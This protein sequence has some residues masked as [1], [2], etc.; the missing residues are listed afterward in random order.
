MIMAQIPHNETERLADLYALEIL[1][2]ASE[3]RFDRITR[4]ATRLFDV[5][6][7]YVAMID[8]NRQW[9]K[10]KQGLCHESTARDISFCAHTI[11]RDEP[12]VIHDAREDDRFF[13]NPMVTGE[14]H[15]VFYAGHPLRGPGGTNVATLCVV[16]QK[17][18]SWSERDAQAFADLAAMVERELNM[19][20]LIEAQK[21]LLSLKNEIV[22]SRQALTEELN[23]AA[24]YVR[25]LLP[26]PM[27]T[28]L[29]LDWRYHA[30]SKLGGDAFG[31]HWL[32]DEHLAIYLLDVT[33]HGISSALLSI[34]IMNMI[35]SASLPQPADPHHVLTTLNRS[36]PMDDHDNKFFTMWYG[37]LHVPT[38]QLRYAGGGHPPALLISRGEN[39]HSNLHQLHSQG[40]VVGV[41]PEADY[42][43]TE[44]MLNC[45]D[46]LYLYSDGVFELFDEDRNLLTLSG[47]TELLHR[48][49]HAD[50]STPFLDRLLL[51]LREY[52]GGADD[53]YDDVSL[54][55]LHL[56]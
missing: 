25:S 51:S 43:V 23:E 8:A 35:R 49:P 47:F 1:D 11:L 2:T 9:F 55:E 33:G 53:F 40:L 14:P 46:R 52:Q 28:P 26:Q 50:H 6:I 54:V 13:D 30:S 19:Y 24:S 10:S 21:E 29:R 17:P 56:S 16:D 15:V 34:S 4:L 7:A 5:P 32:D 18:R 45:G 38:R 48:T 36:F 31:Y 22:A 41:D 39:G 12:L 42:P 20:S 44:H 3:D 27:E 37:V